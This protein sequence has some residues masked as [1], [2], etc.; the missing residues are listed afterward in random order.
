[1]INTARPELALFMKNFGCCCSLARELRWLA[2]WL[3]GCSGYILQGS[4]ARLL[5]THCKGIWSDAGC[6]DFSPFAV[7]VIVGSWWRGSCSDSDNQSSFSSYVIVSSIYSL[8]L[9]KGWNKA[10]LKPNMILRAELW[11]THRGRFTDWELALILTNCT[12]YCIKRHCQ[13]P[14][15]TL[16]N[17]RCSPVKWG[18]CIATTPDLQL[19]IS[20]SL[21]PVLQPLIN[22]VFSCSKEILYS[23]RRVI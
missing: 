7:L 22:T 11:N 13:V 23:R 21:S 18:C 19:N 4:R 8:F 6:R 15:V 3:W 12:S 20:I 14:N 16:E 1:M 17:G 9:R 2:G 10:N 5:G